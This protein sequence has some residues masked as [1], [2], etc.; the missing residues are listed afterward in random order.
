MTTE[1]FTQET[2]LWDHLGQ[3]LQNGK[4]ENGLLIANWDIISAALPHA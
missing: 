2:R 3:R 1:E 4:T